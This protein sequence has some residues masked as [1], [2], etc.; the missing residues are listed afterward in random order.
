MIVCDAYK[1]L[2]SINPVGEVE[3]LTDSAEGVPFLFADDL[4]IASDGKIYFT[5]A[6]SRWNQANYM[7]DLMEGRPWGRL[8]VYDPETKQ[9]SVLMRDMYFA[10]G[11]ALSQNED[12]VLINETWRYRIVRYWL[13][14]EKAGT[15]DLFIEN[16]P[17]FQQLMGIRTENINTH[18]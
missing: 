9:T 8:L 14:G 18:L 6:S 17:G 16:L 13:K 1:G 4:D 12:F 11:V 5:D 15:H 2:L 7:L 10:N 3:V